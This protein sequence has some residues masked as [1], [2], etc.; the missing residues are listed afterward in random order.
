MTDATAEPQEG[1]ERWH[2]TLGGYSNHKC[3]GP[4]CRAAWAEYIRNRKAERA[5][6]PI[7][8]HVHGT[9]NGYGNWGCR[10]ERCTAAWAADFKDRYER[11]KTS[12]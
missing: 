9:S 7:P 12:A 6:G 10:C 2:G 8:E 5:A 11:N 1:D 3:R 4:R